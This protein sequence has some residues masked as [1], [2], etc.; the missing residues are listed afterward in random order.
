MPEKHNITDEFVIFKKI[1]H[2]TAIKRMATISRRICFFFNIFGLDWTHKWPKTTLFG[3][4]T[5][6]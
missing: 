6:V 5:C 1:K 4:K 3:L 2:M